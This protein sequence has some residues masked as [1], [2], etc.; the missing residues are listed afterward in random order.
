MLPVADIDT[1]YYVK[2]EEVL[3]TPGKSYAGLKILLDTEDLAEPDQYYRW[4]FEETWQVII[5]YPP[6]YSYTFIDYDTLKFM[7]VPEP[8]PKCWKKNYS[9]DI[10]INS[11]LSGQGHITGQELLFITP[12]LSDK[13][14]VKYTILVKQYSIS[15]DAYNFWKM[16]RQ[17]EE[18]PGDI[19]GSLPYPVSANIYNISNPGETVLGFFEVAAVSQ[20]R[21]FI[22]SYELLP[23]ALPLFETDCEYI[24]LSPDMWP[25]NQPTWDEIYHSWVFDQHYVFVTPEANAILPGNVG[26]AYVKKFVFTTPVCAFC[27]KSGFTERPDFW[28]DSE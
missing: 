15:E 19:F 28:V 27:E 24:R 9:R 21:I 26:S 11:V 25:D 7:S 17:V 1:L 10:I 8:A 18:N 13:L 16:F 14:T 22:D 20:K 6:Q 4:T 3:G 5:P 12:S 2:S 23:L